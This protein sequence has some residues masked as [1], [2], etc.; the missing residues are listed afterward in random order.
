[1]R[2]FSDVTTQPSLDV[3]PEPSTIALVAIGLIGVIRVGAG[4]FR[5]ACVVYSLLATFTNGDSA[6]HA[7]TIDWVTVGNPG[8]VA[9]TEVMNDSLTG[10]GSV[11][12]TYRISTTEVTNNQY[13]DFLNAVAIDDPGGIFKEPVFITEDGL[14]SSQMNDHSSGGIQRSGEPGNYHY[15]AKTGREHMPVVFVS[16]HDAIRFANWL[17][18]GQPIGAQG[19]ATTEDGAY[20][21]TTET[22]FQNSVARKSEALFFVPTE[23]E[24]YKAAYYKGGGRTAGYWDYPTQSDTPPTADVPPGGSNSANFASVAAGDYVDVGSYVGSPGPYGTYDQG[25]NVAEW[26]ETHQGGPTGTGRYFRGGGQDNSVEKLSDSK[27]DSLRPNSHRRLGFR[28]GAAV[29]EPST[30]IMLLFGLLAMLAGHRTIAATPLRARH[31]R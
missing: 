25:G 1:M 20:Q 26:V 29:P 18:N 17:H 27:H 5:T 16:F 8:N 13:T 3:V 2:R 19:P 15:E 9:D 14:Y 4:R 30:G 23:D 21:I 31:V 22:V 7:V 6:A 28:M 11:S 12:Y 10:Y 24:W